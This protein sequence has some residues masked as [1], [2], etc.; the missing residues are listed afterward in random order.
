MSSGTLSVNEL[1][2]FHRHGFVVIKRAFAPAIANEME[3]R[4]WAELA[5]TYGIQRERPSSWFQPKTDLKAAKHDSLQAEILNERV[6]GVVDDLLHVSDWS[7][8]RD[9]GRPIVTFP[10]PGAWDVPTHLWHWDSP[11]HWHL[12]RLSSLFVVS[13][14]GNVA[15]R[16]GGT[17]LL[18]GSPQ[19]LLLQDRQLSAADRNLYARRRELF[20]DSHPWLAA[21]AG[22][23]PSPHD[24]VTAFMR[25]GATIDGVPLRVV[26]LTGEAGD[27]VFCHGSIA[28]C[29]A[30]NRGVAPRFMRIKQQ[31]MTHE[32]RKL[33]NPAPSNAS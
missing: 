17:L 21:L 11:S 12:E 16:S 13:F 27:M 10:V 19:L 1:E 26:E 9:W 24:R 22:Q 32:G 6:R 30:P 5:D 8:P 2:H 33:L 7:P 31:L 20:F 28:H 14:V 25:E 23:A 15:P 29:G 18:S 4:W 3:R